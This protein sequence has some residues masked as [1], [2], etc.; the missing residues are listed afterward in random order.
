MNYANMRHTHADTHTRNYVYSGK[1]PWNN[2]KQQ[3]AVIATKPLFNK[4][5]CN[6]LR[7][8]SEAVQLSDRAKRTVKI[9]TVQLRLQL[10]CIIPFEKCD[11][12]ITNN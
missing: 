12:L 2:C 1:F 8:K 7:S 4:I 11:T 6:L 10:D 5:V 3:C 9:K